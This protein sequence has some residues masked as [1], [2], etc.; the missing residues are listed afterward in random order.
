MYN[1]LRHQYLLHV[2]SLRSWIQN[3]DVS[4]NRDVKNSVAPTTTKYIG[5]NLKVDNVKQKKKN[6]KTRQASV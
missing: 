4:T 5:V 1:K 2:K 3:G 6:E